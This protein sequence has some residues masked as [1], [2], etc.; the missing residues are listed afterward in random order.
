MDTEKK[1]NCDHYKTPDELYA[2]FRDACPSCKSKVIFDCQSKCKAFNPIVSFCEFFFALLPYG[3][4]LCP[5]V[6]TIEFKE[7]VESYRKQSGIKG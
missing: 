1:R 5:R 4:P 6:D 2:A 3:E 7:A